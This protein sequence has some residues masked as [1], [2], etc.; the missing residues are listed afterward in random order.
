MTTIILCFIS[1]IVGAVFA[2]LVIALVSANDAHEKR[3]WWE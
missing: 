3:K 2:F 1:F